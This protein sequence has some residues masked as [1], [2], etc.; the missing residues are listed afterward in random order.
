MP[1]CAQAETPLRLLRG[2][3]A[4]QGHTNTGK[5]SQRNA[6]PAGDIRQGSIGPHRYTCTATPQKSGRR[7]FPR[8]APLQV[9]AP[10]ERTYHYT[11]RPHR[12]R[13]GLP[14]PPKAPRLPKRPGLPGLTGV[15]KPPKVPGLPKLPGKCGKPHRG[16]HRYTPGTHR[17]TPR[18]PRV[19]KPP[20]LPSPPSPPMLPR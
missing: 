8:T 20:R 17:Y 3:A 6:A 11:P 15:P 5:A 14:R 16:T 19:P 12:Y 1:N 9:A 13:F 7:I 2:E 4:P 10:T 18:P